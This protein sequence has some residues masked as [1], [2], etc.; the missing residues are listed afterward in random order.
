MR[1]L[2]FFPVVLPTVAVAPHE[3]PNAFAAIVA[4]HGF[5]LTKTIFNIGDV[6]QPDLLSTRT[7]MPAGTS[8]VSCPK[9]TEASTRAL[10]AAAEAFSSCRS[11]TNVKQSDI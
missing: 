10:S 6:A 8:T 9:P 7:D 11:T 4:R 3:Q 2:V 1:T 5:A